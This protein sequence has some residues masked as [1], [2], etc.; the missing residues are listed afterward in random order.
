MIR[1]DSEGSHISWSHRHK[2]NGQFPW[3][4]FPLVKLQVR[5][6]PG[7][8][9]TVGNNQTQGSTWF[10]GQ[11]PLTSD[12]CDAEVSTMCIKTGTT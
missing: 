11:H 7:A 4:T 3:Q 9:L 8:E 12:S 10:L 5:I 6:I 2:A 1:E